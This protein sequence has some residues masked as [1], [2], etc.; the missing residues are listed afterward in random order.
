MESG[1]VFTAINKSNISNFPI[2]YPGKKQ[3]D[4]FNS[5]VGVLDE[6]I[7]INTIE[8]KALAETRD[9]LLPKLM[10]GEIRVPVEEVLEVV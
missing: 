10:S 2:I 4:S 9:T 8:S 6:R 3:V 7:L 5:V 1:S